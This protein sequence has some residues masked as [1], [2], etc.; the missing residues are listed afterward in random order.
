M[1]PLVVQAVPYFSDEGSSYG[2]VVQSRAKREGTIVTK[3][4][5][6][7]IAVV[8]SVWVWEKRQTQCNA[9]QTTNTS[10]DPFYL[11]MNDNTH[12][13]T[14]TSNAPFYLSMNDNI[15]QTTNTSNAPFYLLMNRFC[16]VL[17][18]LHLENVTAVMHHF[19]D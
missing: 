9:H 8:T 10:N 17:K 19:V 4:W 7:I 6:L 18:V 5:G 3:G 13:T 14:N 12:Q 11:S 2:L 16:F 15:H 1:E